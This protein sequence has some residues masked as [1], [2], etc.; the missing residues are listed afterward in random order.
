MRE[1]GRERGRKAGA[2]AA[3][4][5]LGARMQREFVAMKQLYPTLGD[6]D[7]AAAIRAYDRERLA[8]EPDYGKYPEL[9]G[10][11]ERH[12][13]ER[14]GF[15]E[16]SG[17]DE[18]AAAFH[19]SWW[20]YL[21]RRVGAHHLARYDLI[22]PP[23]NCTNVFFPHGKDG[24][25]ISDNR[26]DWTRPEYQQTIPG[27][28][29]AAAVSGE[30]LHW[31]QG[32]VSSAMLFDEE[33]ECCFPF[34]PFE[35]IPADCL[36]DIHAIVEFMTRYREF[37][38]PGNLIF[39]DRR[40]NAVAVEKTNC[41]VAF[42]WP[43][44][45]GAVCV[46]AC[47]YLDPELNAYKREGTRK[48]MAIKGDSEADSTDRAYFEG[49]DRRQRRLIELT[50][51][52]A[53]DG[54]TLWGAFNV[55]ADTAVPFP[56]RIC[57]AGEKTFPE[58][59]PTANWTLTQHAA[60]VSGSHRRCLYRSLQDVLHPRAITTFTP[61][62]LLGPGVAMQSAWQQDLDEG[63]CVEAP[64]IAVPSHVDIEVKLNRADPV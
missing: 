21:T 33:P 32:G 18:T 14:E 37:Y 3:A 55:V 60:V 17:L 29:P 59:E 38:G 23:I 45:N 26:D 4:A 28:R 30:A 42:R 48:A 24:V 20:F 25:T 50:N 41:R 19:Y 2:G 52:E 11:L 61:K 53:K 7:A 51:A 8:C 34:D 40:L 10:L 16:A 27:F 5:D 39:C 44:V 56:D 1:Q 36:D 62:L 12:L 47:S 49:A 63:R 35:M 54:A 64:A 15:M 57:L 22:P 31:I 13:G 6:I 58:R 43:E 9:N 46:T